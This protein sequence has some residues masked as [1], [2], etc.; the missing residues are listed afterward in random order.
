MRSSSSTSLRCVTSMQM[1]TMR[2]GCALL[3]GK[4]PAAGFHPGDAAFRPHD[5]IL[6][7]D[8][9]PGWPRRGPQRQA[10]GVAIVRV[11]ALL[12]IFQLSAEAAGIHAVDSLQ[13]R[14]PRH[15]PGAD[16][17]FPRAHAAGVQ[18]PVPVSAANPESRAGPRAARLHRGKPGP[19]RS[20]HLLVAHGRT[21]VV[22]GDQTCHPASPGT[23]GSR[24][25]RSRLPAARGRPGSRRARASL[26]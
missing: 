7:P 12:K 1:P 11:H 25:P 22:D 5:P 9:P 24:A 21:A 15:V 16:F 17:P 14:R 10:H 2:S 4:Q 23:Y 20:C 19:L 6:H 13:V 26:H 8:R 3:I 18:T